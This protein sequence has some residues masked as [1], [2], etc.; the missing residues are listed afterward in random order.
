VSAYG[1]HSDYERPWTLRTRPA[2]HWS[3]RMVHEVYT[4]QVDNL[5]GEIYRRIEA[6]LDSQDHA[7]DWADWM[8]ERYPERYRRE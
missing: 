4:Y 6:V 3:G 1:A 5:T 8:T 7:E 2:K